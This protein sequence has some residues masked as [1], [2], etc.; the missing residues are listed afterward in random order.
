MIVGVGA[1]RVRDLFEQA[2]KVAPAIIFIDEIDAIGRSRSASSFGG[3]RRAGAD[4]Q[5]D[6]HRDGWVHRVRGRHRAR[7]HQ[8]P[9]VARPGPAA[10]R[11]LRP[12]GRRSPPDQAGRR[13]ILAVHTR[14]VPL[15]PTST[16]TTSRRH[17]RHG[18]RGPKNLV[19]EAAL[20]AAA[21]R[22]RRGRPPGTSPT[23]WRRSS[24]APSVTSSHRRG[25]TARTAYH[26]SGHAL[27]GMLT[28]GADPVRKISIIPRGQALGVTFQSP[29][30]TA[31]ATPPSTCAAGSSARW[32][33]GP[34]R[35][36]CSATSPPAPRTTSSGPH[37]PADG[38]PMG[39]VRGDRP[40]HRAATAGS[41]RRS[42]ATASHRPPRNS[43]TRGP[44]DLDACYDEALR[45]CAAPRP[46]RPVGHALLEA[47][48]PR[49]GR[50]VRGGRHQREAAPAAVAR[51]EAA[52]VK[53]A[54]GLPP[55]GDVP[56]GAD[57]G[58]PVRTT[59]GLPA[60]P[61]PGP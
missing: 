17:S 21:A 55:G 5:P 16:S 13:Q 19:N 32:A 46:A 34:P 7:R 50:G 43:S 6:P 58:V 11:P 52:G 30:P 38:R 24:S 51:G 44:Q 2:R 33:A 28:P 45:P 15:A 23:R 54:P 31:T 61:P 27:L 8:P 4:P 3:A 20:L 60:A 18:R 37:R 57:D 26:E 39:D 53:P 59:S 25:R 35:S 47:R 22:P 41:E 56:A 12:A 40:G 49:R 10:P 48:D 42:A 14:K 29:Q 9:R 36:S 1:S